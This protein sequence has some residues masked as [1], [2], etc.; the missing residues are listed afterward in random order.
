MRL[1]LGMKKNC[2]NLL[3]IFINI[4]IYINR[5]LSESAVLTAN[6]VLK[7]RYLCKGKYF[8]NLNIEKNLTVRKSVVKSNL[9]N[10][11]TDIF[12]LDLSMGPQPN[13]N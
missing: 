6:K 4:Y 1:A 12:Y 5:V 10:T 9:K 3:C 8:G 11:L 13:V 7:F 2:L